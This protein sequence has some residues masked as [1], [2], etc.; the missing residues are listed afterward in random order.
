[1]LHALSVAVDAT[2]RRYQFTPRT[3]THDDYGQK[4]RWFLPQG[5]SKHRELHLYF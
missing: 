4:T 5:A 2:R 1:M 3:V